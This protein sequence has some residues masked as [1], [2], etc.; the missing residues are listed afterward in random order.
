M[1]PATIAD[2]APTETWTSGAAPMPWWRRHGPVLVALG[3]VLTL[4]TA[5][6]TRSTALLEP[7]DYAYR[8]SIVALTQGHL[9]LSSA[10]YQ[11]L[12]H[13]L[14]GIQQWVH[15]S[16][17]RWISE[18]N[19]GYP[20]LAAPF[21]AIGLLRLAPV[22]YGALGCAGLY[23]G[24][25]RWLGRWGGTFAVALFCSSGAALV[26]AWRATMPT[27]TG[28]ALVAGGLGA[29]VWTL[30]AAAAAP[31]HRL[32]VGLAGFVALEA[33]VAVRYT[34]VG[35]LVV[36]AV[37]VLV[38][39]RRTELSWAAVGTWMASIAVAGLAILGFNQAVYGHATSTGYAAGE[40]TFSLSAIWPN[41]QVMPRHLLTA[42]PLLVPALLAVA[43]ITIRVL[44]TLT[45]GLTA[46]EVRHFRRDGAIG[47]LLLASWAVCW[48]LYLAYDWTA[49]MSGG[50]GGG[51]TVH[52]VRF[53]V[54][55]LGA[56]ALLG[57]W[58]LRQLPRW[59]PAAVLVVVATLGLM[60]YASMASGAGGPG[61][62]GGPAGQLGPGSGPGAAG[63]LSAPGGA[64]VAGA[65]PRT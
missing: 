11:A 62:P 8:A 42:M 63:A 15:L 18:K 45:P 20:F 4:A 43:W 14:G 36:A 47:A 25:R 38:L 16:S 32:V 64:A 53:Y 10:Q 60:S 40:I 48:G 44:L 50:G 17:G 41:L 57:A 30:S 1:P 7:D 19:P 49:Q 34:D 28:A 29:L 23:A 54:P 5:I 65:T 12:A 2:L 13:Q 33:A 27:F 9:T 55:A 56:M 61:G 31:R 51:I 24:G 22:F 39:R 37:A 6:L 59:L 35:Q 58:F 26:F 52:V 21:Q 46:K 3:C